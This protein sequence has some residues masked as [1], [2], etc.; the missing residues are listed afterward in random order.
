MQ[1]YAL[2]RRAML[3]GAGVAVAAS[4]LP[5]R[6][7]TPVAAQPK[8]LMDR[9]VERASENRLRM[10]YQGGRFSGPG[11]DRL[12]SEGRA[13]H[14]FMVGEE[15][16]VAEVPKL[17][18]QLAAALK[19]AGYERLAIEVSPPMTAEIEKVAKDGYAGLERFMRANAPG[20]AFYTMREEAQM[21]A[22]V[23]KGGGYRFWGLD[24]EIMGDPLL[25]TRLRAKAPA[26]AKAPM[27][28]LYTVVTDARAKLLA[29]RQQQHIFAFAGDPE[30]VRAVRRAWPSPDAESGWILD[31]LE[32]TLEINQLWT[33]G[34]GWASNARRTAFLRANLR[35]H[36]L[37]EKAAGRAPKTLFKFGAYHT[38]RGRSGTEVYDIGEFAPAIA[39]LE[40]SHS[41]HL[42]VGAGMDRQ[43]AGINL[44]TFGYDP[45]PSGLYKGAFGAEALAALAYPDAPTLI[46]LRPLRPIMSARQT[47]TADPDLV[48]MIHGFDSMLVLS[49]STPSASMM[50]L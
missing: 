19:P 33:K 48:R 7:Q 21:L 3:A 27:D 38:A 13:A 20:V 25:V 8:P 4:A 1:S 29:T 14:F 47:K 45:G 26:S 12:V 50:T 10:D 49:G 17:V 5:A 30:L 31:T 42:L 24:Y 35:R 43:V 32:E 34:Q 11:W 23:A 41:Y 37:A 46:D 39:E 9:L 18:G 40:G 36:W 44:T 28:A 22:D 15:H 6:A 16:G 2:S